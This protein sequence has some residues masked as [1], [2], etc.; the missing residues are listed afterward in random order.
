MPPEGAI[1]EVS[2]GV[3]T[4]RKS[5]LTIAA[6]AERNGG[7]Y[8]N[9]LH[10]IADPRSTADYRLTHKRRLEALRRAGIVE[11]EVAT[12]VSGGAV[13]LLEVVVEQVGRAEFAEDGGAEVLAVQGAVGCQDLV[14]E[15]GHQHGVMSLADAINA[16]RA[17]GGRIIANLA[18]L[19]A[20]K[21][22][23]KGVISV[24]AAGGQG[25]TAILE[26]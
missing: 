18:K 10:E 21:G 13:E 4:A 6:I 22:S 16:A 5:D 19:L 14:G 9:E 17:S 12:A 20:E 1:I 3:G 15:D 25:V 11:R 7:V 23:G 2:R 8:S 24:C 26:A